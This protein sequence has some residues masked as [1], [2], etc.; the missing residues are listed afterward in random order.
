[1]EGSEDHRSREIGTL[2]NNKPDMPFIICVYGPILI[3]NGN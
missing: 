3:I 1:L 2:W